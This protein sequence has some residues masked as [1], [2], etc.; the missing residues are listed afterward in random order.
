[1]QEHTDIQDKTGEKPEAQENMLSRGL[2]SRA[3]WK[4]Q[5]NLRCAVTTSARSVYNRPQRVA[6]QR[7]TLREECSWPCA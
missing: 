4:F 2:D 7:P 1:M 5:A 3:T 6:G